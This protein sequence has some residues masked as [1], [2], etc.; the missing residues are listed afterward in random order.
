MNSGAKQ[1]KM[2]KV[3]E[4]LPYAIASKT[5]SSLNTSL[6]ITNPPINLSNSFSVSKNNTVGC[7]LENFPVE[8][9]L[10]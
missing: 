9:E 3:K 7:S 5:F 10:V 6:S 4:V 8:K 2:F 1:K